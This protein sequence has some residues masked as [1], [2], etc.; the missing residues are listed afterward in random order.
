MVKLDHF[1]RNLIK[2]NL[3]KVSAYYRLTT[4]GL[5]LCIRLDA[6]RVCVNSKIFSTLSSYR[7]RIG[8][9]GPQQ[10]IIYSLMHELG[11]FIGNRKLTLEEVVGKR[12]QTFLSN[13]SV[14][15]ER[16]VSA[17]ENGYEYFIAHGIPV[18]RGYSRRMI[19][20]LST[21]VAVAE[22]SK[23]YWIDTIGRRAAVISS[24]EDKELGA[25]D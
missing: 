20:S 23:K 10:E 4:E 22:E 21:Y 7:I 5:S 15:L 14:V 24:K 19:K 17:W 6:Q 9:D 16:E 25:T 8:T 1:L 11:H 18:P 2:K 3:E 13:P 12:F